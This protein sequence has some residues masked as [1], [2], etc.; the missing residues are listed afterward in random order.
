MKDGLL[1]DLESHHRKFAVHLSFLPPT[2]DC[3][4]EPGPVPEIEATPIAGT[5]GIAPEAHSPMIAYRASDARCACAR[6]L[7]RSQPT[8]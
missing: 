2:T 1:L 7:L 5:R 3:A 4:R 8:R 6:D